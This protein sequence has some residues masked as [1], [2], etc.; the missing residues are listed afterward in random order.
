MKIKIL[1]SHPSTYFWVGEEN[2][3]S[4][5][6]INNINGA[7]GKNVWVRCKNLASNESF[8]AEQKMKNGAA[9]KK[10]W[11]YSPGWCRIFSA[12]KILHV[13]EDISSRGF[14]FFFQAFLVEDFLHFFFF[15]WRARVEDY[16]PRG[17]IVGSHFVS[18]EGANIFPSLY[19]P[20]RAAP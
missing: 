13:G 2:K 17:F 12:L 11:G 20:S 10:N 3:A 1:F 6:W 5:A 8:F 15:F 16:P 14:F 18:P 19:A 7:A 4:R 9:G